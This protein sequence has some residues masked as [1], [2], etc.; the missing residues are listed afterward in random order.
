MGSWKAPTV[1]SSETVLISPQSPTAPE[2]RHLLLS[3]LDR[4]EMRIFTPV[5]LLYS[6]PA[7]GDFQ[8]V[9][10]SLKDSL[11]KALVEYYPFAG[12]FT[13][14]KDGLE[15]IRCDDA[16][17]FFTE[18]V[19]EEELQEIGGFE[20]CVML[21]GME[22]ANLTSTGLHSLDDFQEIPPLVIQVLFKPEFKP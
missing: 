11:R 22:A 13:R 12:R 3:N 17:A 2:K 4:I 19:V 9:V 6:A 7:D 15:E 5:I 20:G 18:A 1:K 21:S 14:G 8:T 16:G 10:G